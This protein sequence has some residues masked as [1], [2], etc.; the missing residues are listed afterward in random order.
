VFTGCLRKFHDIHVKHPSAI[1]T[2]VLAQIASLYQIEASI[3][4]SPAPQR[5]T[6]R[7]AQAKPLIDALY[8]YLSEQQE[9][10]SRKSVTAEAIGYA[11]NHWGA[12]TRYRKHPVTT[13]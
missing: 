5:Q 2:Q 4:G 12:L 9:R 3:R 11:M 8:R 1:T 10:I 7:Q 6:I 13:V